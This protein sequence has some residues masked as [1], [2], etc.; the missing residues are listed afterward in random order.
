MPKLIG[1]IILTFLSLTLI[2]GCSKDEEIVEDLSIGMLR[3]VNALR[4]E[5]CQCG[6][7]FMPPVSEM[8]WNNSLEFSAKS[9]AKYMYDNHYFSHISLDGKSPIERAMAA[10]YTGDPVGE[11]IAK[12]Y[13]TIKDVVN[14]WKNSEGHCKAMMDSLYTEMGAGKYKKYWVLDMGKPL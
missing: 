2:F 11:D 1:K 12:G 7:D 8:K 9:Y 10:G 3:E 14:A 13:S 4:K 6:P 5:G